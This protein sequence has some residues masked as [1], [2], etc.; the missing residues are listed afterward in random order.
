M[1]KN[2]MAAGGHWVKRMGEAGFRTTVPGLESRPFPIAVSVIPGAVD[3]FG[4]WWDGGD[5]SG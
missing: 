5:G 4:A 2:G 1:T 3:G